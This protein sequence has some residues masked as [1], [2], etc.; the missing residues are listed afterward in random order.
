LWRGEWK[1]APAPA[2]RLLNQGLVVLIVAVITVALSN[3]F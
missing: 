2:R 1:D 3:S